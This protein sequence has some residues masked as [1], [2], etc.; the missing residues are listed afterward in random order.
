MRSIQVNKRLRLGVALLASGIAFSVAAPA[1]AQPVYS[2]LQEDPGTALSRHLKTLAESPRNLGALTGAAKAALELGDVQAAATFYARAEEVAPR[3]GRIKAGLGSAFL[4]MEQ[5]QAALKFFEDARTLGAPEGEYAADRGLAHDL[6]GNPSQAQRDYALAMRTADTPEVRRRMALSKAISGDRAGALAIIDEQLRRQDRAA[7]RVRAFVLALTGDANGATEAVR[8]VMPAQAAAMQPFLAR[9]PA[10]RPA[11]RA[12]AVH[13]GH[14]PNDG[15]AIQVAQVPQQYASVTPVPPRSTAPM[16]ATPTPTVSSRRNPAA[17]A[18]AP[19]ARREQRG[20]AASFSRRRSGSEESGLSFAEERDLLR[21]GG[22]VRRRGVSKPVEARPEPART[23]QPARIA[24]AEPRVAVP[25]QNNSSSAPA[26]QSPARVA[27]PPAQ[28][29]QAPTPV[30]TKPITAPPTSGPVQLADAGSLSRPVQGPPGDAGA[31]AA[32][33][34]DTVSR[35]GPANILPQAAGSSGPS[36]AAAGTADVAATAADAGTGLTNLLPSS[37][38]SAAVP[39]AAAPSAP[40]ADIATVTPPPSSVSPEV[41]PPPAAVVSPAASSGLAG[42]A[43]TIR[44]LPDEAPKEEPKPPVKVAKAEPKP[45]PKKAPEK[46]QVAE[47]EAP[48]RHWVQIA[49]ASD[50]LAMGEYK[51]LKGKAPK[52][53][54]GTTGWKASFRSTNRV[55]VGPFKDQKEA[56]ELVNELAKSNIAAVPWKS[57]D[58][59][60]IEK[61]A[62]K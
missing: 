18:T 29:A 51:R 36:T 20:D 17:S 47:A 45:E 55:L 61:L 49:S 5:A 46:E 60:E 50:A 40:N 24:R 54:G 42:L 12:M 32:I 38:A 4:A 9:L 62:A 2:A 10:L 28:S 22:T 56:Q 30:A 11:D 15:G 39:P 58:G 59:Q 44:A 19:A 3:D 23:E 31:P 35:G 53:L 27:A 7:W 26:S 21:G 8:A 41:A 43:A 48:S 1:A 52:L 16:V 57:A 33:A 34:A 37:I 6:L 14:F 13:F 25:I